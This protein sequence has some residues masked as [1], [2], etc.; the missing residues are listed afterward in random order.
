MDSSSGVQDAGE[1]AGERHLDPEITEAYWSVTDSLGRAA[2][3]ETHDPTF[4]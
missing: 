2:T 1:Q 4:P 3:V